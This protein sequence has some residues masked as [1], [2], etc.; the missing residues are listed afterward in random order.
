[1]TSAMARVSFVPKENNRITMGK[2]TLFTY[3]RTNHLMKPSEKA[4][5]FMVNKSAMSSANFYPKLKSKLFSDLTQSTALSTVIDSRFHLFSKE[6]VKNV[7]YLTVMSYHDVN[8]KR[9]KNCFKTIDGI[10]HLKAYNNIA[11]TNRRP[12][13]I[14]YAMSSGCLCVAAIL[15]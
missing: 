1:M 8:G 4:F 7:D 11:A 2:V 15:L 5:A 9:I 12:E 10:K 14:A 3:N 13:D 6:Y